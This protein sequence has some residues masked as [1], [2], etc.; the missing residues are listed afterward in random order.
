MLLAGGTSV[1]L[2]ILERLLGTNFKGFGLI[3]DFN[4]VLKAKLSVEVELSLEEESLLLEGLNISLVGKSFGL[5]GDI[6][7]LDDTEIE[8]VLGLT[9]GDNGVLGLI[10]GDNGVLAFTVGDR[11]VFTTGDG[12]VL[13][14]GEDGLLATVSLDGFV[15][16][17]GD[18][19][20]E[21]LDTAIDDVT[22]AFEVVD[23]G[24]TEAVDFSNKEELTDDNE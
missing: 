24:T 17:V 15:I 23:F 16:V 19:G 13:T 20:T 10:V 4:D 18:L 8:A 21:F 12:K 9:I 11:G 14:V 6:G 3:G 1:F 7:G 22:V 2:I 5:A